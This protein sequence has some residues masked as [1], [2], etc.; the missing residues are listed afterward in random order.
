MNTLI[1]TDNI[2]SGLTYTDFSKWGRYRKSAEGYELV[3]LDLNFGLPSK[4][5][6]CDVKKEEAHFYEL[7]VEV[8]K[9]LQAGGVVVALLGPIAVTDRDLKQ[10]YPHD[11]LPDKAS[12]AYE[13]K[14]TETN[15]TSYDWLDQGFLQDTRVDTLFAKMS[16]GITIISPAEMGTYVSSWVEEYWITINGIDFYGQTHTM[17]TITH[18]VAQPDRWNSSTVGQYPVK[19]LGVGRHTRL[20]VAVAMQYM[21][22]D[23]VLIL[24]PPF[25]LRSNTTTEVTELLHTLENLAIAIKED[26]TGTTEHEEW[27]YEHRAPQAKDIATQIEEIRH[28]KKELADRLQAYDLMLGLVDGT[29]KAVEGSVIALFDKSEE[30]LTVEKTEKGAPIDLFVMDDKGRR[31]VI[32]VTGIRH[33]LRKNDPHWADFLGYIPE[34]NERN[35]CGRVE[36]IVLVVNTECKTKIEERNRQNDMSEPVKGTATDN[37]ICVIRSYDLYGLWLEVLA[38]SKSVRDIFD[39]LFD[40]DGIWEPQT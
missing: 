16:K 25:V 29:G 15:E 23:G 24:L 33:A 2:P 35:E 28:Q 37:H 11:F 6:F 5:G 8:A 38:G 31:L 14:F 27:V 34:H 26:F 22:W 30:G 20:P 19:V 4:E 12:Y 36:R 32:E 39:R 9:S 10:I 13:K 18:S 7:G 17:G 1:I 21:N 3:I 40:C